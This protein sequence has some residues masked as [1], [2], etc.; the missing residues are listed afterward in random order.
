MASIIL[1]TLSTASI[2]Q[3]ALEEYAAGKQAEAEAD[4]ALKEV[5]EVREQDVSLC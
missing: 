4:A 2:P 3:V 1:I 5:K